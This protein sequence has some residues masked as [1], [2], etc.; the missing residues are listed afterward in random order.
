MR[1]LYSVSGRYDLCA[2]VEVDSPQ[3]MDTLLDRIRSLPG[4]TETVS[5][6]FLQQKLK[7]PT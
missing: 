7:R 6:L 3:G 4:V 5:T 1:E 2:L